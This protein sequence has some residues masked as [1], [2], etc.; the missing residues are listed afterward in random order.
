MKQTNQVDNDRIDKDQKDKKQ[1]ESKSSKKTKGFISKLWPK[2][3]WKKV[4]ILVGLILLIIISVL[5]V[6]GYHT[7]QTALNLKSQA[8][9]LKFSGQ[10]AYNLF[11]QQNLP[12]AQEKLTEVKTQLE[13]I[14]KT[15]QSQLNLYQN[16]P[17]IKD[18][19]QDGLHG[20]KAGKH[21]LEAALVSLQALTPYADVLGFKGE[22]SFAGGTAEN[23]I[24]IMLDT[25]DKVMPQFDQIEQELN[26]AKKELNQINPEH[27]PEEIEGV[28]VKEQLTTAQTM[29]AQTITLVSEFRPVLEQLPE[30]AGAKGERKKYLILFQNDNELRPTGGF[31]TAYA[32]V[33]IEDGVVTP[34]KSDDIYE[35]DQKFNAQVPIPETLGRYLTTEKYWNLRDMNTS[36]DFKV[37][38]EQFFENYQKIRGEPEGIDGIIA[39]DT[40]VLTRLLEIVGPTNVPGYGT[41]SAEEDARCD[42]PQ[43]VYALSQIITKPTPYMREDRKGVLGPLMQG[44]LMKTYATPKQ[45]FPELFSMAWESIKGRHTQMYFSDESAQQAAEAV[46]AGGRIKPTE[47]GDFLAIV[48]ANLGGAKSNLFTEYKVDQFIEGPE[49]GQITKTVEITYRNTRP[50]DNCNLEAGELCLNSTL[51]D[52]HRLYLPT[53]TQLVKAQGFTQEPKEYEDLGFHVIDGFFKL[54]PKGVAKVKIT[55]TVPYELDNY[56]LQIWKQGGIDPYETIIDVNGG[57]E[58]LLI[59]QDQTF[60]T[61]F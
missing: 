50:A 18:Y 43:V 15:Y 44:V 32:V 9:K 26:A 5:A 23:R 49:N 35:L 33:F 10:E 60:E 4:I 3:T 17:L 21:G 61:I 37:S 1:S 42:C 34:E 8:N 51:Q 6:I 13:D 14:E 12:Q 24:K 57:Q 25:L 16:L 58:K 46:A 39:V 7:Y 40:N 52:W 2:K 48:D 54:E 31:L 22:G 56:Q 28:K 29:A 55:Y 38:M 41:F 11:K 30:I 36:P 27:Y 19:Y 53:G 47:Q 45:K 59:D 20:L